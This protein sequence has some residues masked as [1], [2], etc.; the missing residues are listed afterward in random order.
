VSIV[1]AHL[2]VAGNDVLEQSLVD[3]AIVPL[4]LKRDPVNLTGLDL[5]R[6]VISVHLEDTV[7]STL[8]LLQDLESFWLVTGGDNTIGNFSGDDLGGRGIDGV[9]KSDKVTER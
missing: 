8:L 2:L 5:G 1:N 9:R 3:L 7:L 4:L 6:N